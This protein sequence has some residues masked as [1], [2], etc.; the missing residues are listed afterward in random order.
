MNIEVQCTPLRTTKLVAGCIRANNAVVNNLKVC[1]DLVDC[2]GNPLSSSGESY[3]ETYFAGELT[4]AQTSF[5]LNSLN[6]TKSV[7][8]SGLNIRNLY[9]LIQDCYLVSVAVTHWST[10]DVEV[11]ALEV[12]LKNAGGTS[13]FREVN[14]G[15][16]QETLLHTYPADGEPIF[17]T[18]GTNVL[19]KVSNDGPV[20]AEILVRL[21]F[22]LDL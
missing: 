1:D 5:T 3:W 18:A 14:L 17:L 16:G 10:A 11:G 15:T 13:F 20:P 7:L 22:A 2:D 4:Q 8:L 12:E 9:Q 6:S 19:V 21:G